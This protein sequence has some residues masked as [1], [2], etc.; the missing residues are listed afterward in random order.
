MTASGEAAGDGA[1]GSEGRELGAIEAVVSDLDGVVWRGD[2]MLPGAVDFF[3]VLR[4]RGMR[5]AFA[6]NNSGKTPAQ[7]VA[8]LTA[9]GIPV[10]E[11]QI[12]TSGVVTARYLAEHHAP[13]TVVHVLGNPGLR[14]VIAAQGFTVTGHEDRVGDY[15]K[16]AVVVASIDRELSYDRLAAA[17][18][19]ILAGADFIGTNGDPTLPVVGGL[20]PGSG[21]VIAALEAATGRRAKLMGKPEAP[22]FAHALEVLGSGPGRTLMIGDRLDTDI[23]GARRAG[24]L[25]AL[26]LTGST[27]SRQAAESA[28]GSAPDLVCDGLP[29]LLRLLWTGSPQ[30]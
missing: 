24:L 8:R 5:M 30:C 2:E 28:G 6:T 29:A 16:A 9:V 11:H 27:T 17:M 18:A 12:V 25:T 21:T 14:S 26:V 22:M 10:E 20:L 19:A 23:L 15:P 4:S 1:T 7:Y 3:S 13:G